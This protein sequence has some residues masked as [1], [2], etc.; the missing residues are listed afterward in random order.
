MTTT[1]TELDLNK[2]NAIRP[3]SEDFNLFL[4]NVLKDN[5]SVC[6]LTYQDQYN[7]QYVIEDTLQDILQL[8]NVDIKDFDS[9]LE[10]AIHVSSSFLLAFWSR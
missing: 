1:T 7:L 9:R 4:V 2:Y 6:S 10:S 8:N 5:D 3:Q